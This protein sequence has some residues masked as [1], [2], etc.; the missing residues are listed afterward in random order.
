MTSNITSKHHLHAQAVA[1]AVKGG[2]MFAAM[3]RHMRAEHAATLSHKQL[4]LMVCLRAAHTPASM[5][6]VTSMPGA[7][8]GDPTRD[9]P[10]GSRPA[11][12][13]LWRRRRG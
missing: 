1:A 9:V 3:W 7:T 2:E 11:C 13:G 8:A 10:D 5:W 12:A 4:D 6:V